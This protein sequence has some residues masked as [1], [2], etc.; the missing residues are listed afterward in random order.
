MFKWVKIEKPWGKPRWRD[1][2]LSAGPWSGGR[3]R[4][5]PPPATPPEPPMRMPPSPALALP[6]CTCK[7]SS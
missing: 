1:V 5:E 7:D 6:P 2:P 3:D 4:R